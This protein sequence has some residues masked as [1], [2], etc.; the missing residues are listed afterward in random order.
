MTGDAELLAIRVGFSRYAES[1]EITWRNAKILSPVLLHI[2]NKIGNEKL[3]AFKKVTRQKI[4]TE[5]GKELCVFIVVK[6]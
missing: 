5:V 2:G 6:I 3:A 1:A 4:I